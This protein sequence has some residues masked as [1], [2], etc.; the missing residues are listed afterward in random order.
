MSPLYFTPILFFI[1]SSKSNFCRCVEACNHSDNYETWKLYGKNCLK[2]DVE[3]SSHAQQ[4]ILNNGAK[5][6]NDLYT[7]FS[8]QS[9]N[10]LTWLVIFYYYFYFVF[11]S[12][13]KKIIKYYQPH[14]LV[15]GLLWE[16]S[17]GI[18]S[19][20]KIVEDVLQ[21]FVQIWENLIGDCKFL[22]DHLWN[23]PDRI[24]RWTIQFLFG[25]VD[26]ISSLSQS[27]TR[28]LLNS[29]K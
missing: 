18:I 12:F 1:C 10:K 20:L 21:S 16:M 4:W 26:L 23:L 13:C 6:R 22:R 7:H 2:S 27:H 5:K 3:A 9:Y 29:D 14:Q 19:R 11:F 25:Q 15:V 17:V 24:S 28:I 8:Q